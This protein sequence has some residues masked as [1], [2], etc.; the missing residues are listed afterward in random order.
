MN[1]RCRMVRA[2]PAS[3][4]SRAVERTYARSSLHRRWTP[5]DQ[6]TDRIGTP[7][8]SRTR[9]IAAMPAPRWFFRFMYDRESA[10]WDRRRNEPEHRELVER[11]TVSSRAWWPRLDLS[12]TSAAVLAR[13]RWHSRGAVTTSWASTGRLAWSRSRGHK[14]RATRS[15]RGSACTTSAGRCASP[16]R[17]WE[18]SSRS[19]SCSTSRIPRPSS[20][21]SGAACGRAGT[22]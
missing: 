16:T 17:R 15:A 1:M 5:A 11:T 6:F 18:A 14:P 19:W 10:A 20:P 22:C 7:A 3:A 8:G 2:T 9:T 4:A 13:T 12:P 21:R